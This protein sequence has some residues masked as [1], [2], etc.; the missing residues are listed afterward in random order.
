MRRVGCWY[1]KQLENVK[2]LRVQINRSSST[3]ESLKAIDEFPW[4][5]VEVSKELSPV[6]AESE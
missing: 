4:N 5:Q 3:A 1:L 6:G 2:A